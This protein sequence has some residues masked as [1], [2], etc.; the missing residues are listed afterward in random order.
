MCNL[1]LLTPE[2]NSHKAKD[3]GLYLSRS[4]NPSAKISDV[5]HDEIRYVYN[6]SDL[7]IRQL[8]DIYGISKSRVHQIVH[9]TGWT[10]IGEWTD[11]EGKKHK[12]ADSCRYKALGNSIALP[13]WIELAKAVVERYDHPVTMG[14]LFDGIGGFPLSFEIAGAKAIWASEVEPF[15]IAVTERR[16]PNGS[17]EKCDNSQL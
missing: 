11:S 13:F 14:S 15:C 1:Q 4:E 7:S 12:P 2:D 9:E 8:S 17:V 10:D 5:V 16:F 6:N 3:D